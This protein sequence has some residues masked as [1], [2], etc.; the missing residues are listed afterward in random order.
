MGNVDKRGTV[1]FHVNLVPYYLASS[2]IRP[3]F[4]ATLLDHRVLREAEERS[5]HAMKSSSKKV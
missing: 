3:A 5:W 2:T 4:A 1:N